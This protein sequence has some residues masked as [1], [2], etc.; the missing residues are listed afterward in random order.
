MC[1]LFKYGQSWAFHLNEKTP[2]LLFSFHS[3]AYVTNEDNPGPV[4]CRT[5]ETVFRLW[6]HSGLWST[7]MHIPLTR[8][9]GDRQSS[10]DRETL[11][12]TVNNRWFYLRIQW[13]RIG[14]GH[15]T[16]GVSLNEC[17]GAIGGSTSTGRQRS[18][19][20]SYYHVRGTS[21]RIQNNFVRGFH[22][23]FKYL[24]TP[25]MLDQCGS[26]HWGLRHCKSHSH[27]HR[28]RCRR[29]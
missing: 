5:P 28:G 8:W 16:L 9:E 29:R 26:A 14:P 4:P 25:S 13:F 18:L 10:S 1:N 19:F 7:L 21:N 22:S 24:L 2:Q 11:W 12:A 6:C 20:T 23:L 3:S 15:V 17:M 27:I